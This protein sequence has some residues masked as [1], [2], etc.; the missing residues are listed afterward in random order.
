MEKISVIIPAYN[1]E[2]YIERCLLSVLKQTCQSLEIIVVNDGSSDTTG[3]ILNDFSAKDSR[4]KVIHQENVGVSGARNRGLEHATG[5]F[6]GFVDADDEIK[7]EMFAELYRISKDFNAD[8]SHCGFELV[9][10]TCTKAFYGTQ[11]ILNQNQCEAIS[12]LLNGY[13]FE[14]SACTKL[15]KKEVLKNVKFR[16]EIKINEDLL[17]N[18]EAFLNAKKIVFTDE[19]LY[20]YMHNPLSASRAAFKVQAQKDV[21]AV[22]GEIRKKL[23]GTTEEKTINH[24]YVGKL[25][26]VYQT[27]LKNGSKTSFNQ[28]VKNLL[29]KT[30]NIG[31]GKRLL[32]LKYSLLYLPAAYFAALFVY[33][34]WYGKN[35]KWSNH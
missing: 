9:T 1:A 8:I 32:F 13:P 28:Q 34:K 31:L 5:E 18:V 33:N 22:A 3:E 11:K 25:T 29:K 2:K 4:L 21:V 24:F 16:D 17:F 10:P 15:Y 12:S 19:L 35:K 30:D 26:T 23:S 27:L 20:R 14:P 6:I 7:A